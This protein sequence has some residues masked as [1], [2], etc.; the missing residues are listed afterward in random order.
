[1]QRPMPNTTKQPGEAAKPHS[2]SCPQ[3]AHSNTPDSRFC[4]A[5]GA[6]LL[7]M[8][9]LHC[10]AINPAV[11]ASCHQCHGE[12]QVADANVLN[13]AAEVIETFETLPRPPVPIVVWI[14][15]GLILAALTFLGYH[16]YQMFTFVDIPFERA[17]RPT[18]DSLLEGRRGPSYSGTIGP[19]P[20]PAASGEPTEK[21]G[22][23][24]IAPAVPVSNAEPASVKATRTPTDTQRAGRRTAEPCTEEA[25]AFGLCSR[26]LKPA[27]EAKTSAK[28]ETAIT[29]PPANVARKATG[30]APVDTQPCTAGVLALGLCKTESIQRKE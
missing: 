16:V 28:T 1:M 19:A 4:N 12:L 20:A 13:S 22:S 27:T 15:G 7:V 30:Q 26:G 14:A 18:E 9:C 24:A 2:H 21:I 17:T 29:S 6:P 10:G 23:G 11:A 5:C 3:C 8:T 25:A